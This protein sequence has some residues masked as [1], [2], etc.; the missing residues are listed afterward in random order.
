M[1]V[2]I[3]HNEWI[4]N[5]HAAEQEIIP[6]ALQATACSTRSVS[7][8]APAEIYRSIACTQASYPARK[9]SSFDP[10][11]FRTT[12]MRSIWHTR[13]SSELGTHLQRRFC[14]RRSKRCQI[15]GGNVSHNMRSLF[16]RSDECQG[17][18]SR[19][20]RK[21]N[22]QHASSSPKLSP[23]VLQ[24]VSDKRHKSEP[25]VYRDSVSKTAHP[26][27]PERPPSIRHRNFCSW[28]D[29]D[30]KLLLWIW[31]ILRRL[32]P[33]TCDRCICQVPMLSLSRYILGK[34][35]D[36]HFAK[37]QRRLGPCRTIRNGNNSGA[38]CHSW[39]W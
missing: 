3:L 4:L 37:I 14:C 7:S 21:R 34:E 24:S 8:S 5:N 20:W 39:L 13:I 18:V 16:F 25:P 23:L 15:T 19:I 11:S 35:L 32:R 27:V 2:L 10:S 9:I 6:S 33:D 22:A 17:T 12:S 38:N 28:N 30:G 26:S 1:N 31:C 36:R 29:M